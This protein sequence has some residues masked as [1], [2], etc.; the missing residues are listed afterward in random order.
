MAR[1]GKILGIIGVI[2][3]ALVF[4]IYLVAFIIAL[5]AG[6][7]EMHSMAPPGQY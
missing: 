7:A 4:L 5:V 3:G 2:L 1:A 6:S